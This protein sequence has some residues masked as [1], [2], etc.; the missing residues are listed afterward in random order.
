[1]LNVSEISK[2][3]NVLLLKKENPHS[4]PI[5]KNK[6]RHDKENPLIRQIRAAV[7]EHLLPPR[8]TVREVRKWMKKYGIVKS[9]G[10]PYEIS[11]LYA[12]LGNSY[13]GK[14]NKNK[15]YT[16]LD[17]AKNQD[18]VYEYWFADQGKP[19]YMD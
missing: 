15:N 11:S 7:K 12:I 8:F 18:D 2:I 1:M 9:D 17:R 13:I 3:P 4:L 6:L 10:K 16:C 19:L 14:R 5:K